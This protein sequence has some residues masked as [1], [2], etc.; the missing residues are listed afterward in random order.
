MGNRCCWLRFVAASLTLLAPVYAAA[1]PTGP[2]VV[3]FDVLFGSQ[4]Y[5]LVGSSRTD[6]PWHITGIDVV[7]SEPIASGDVNSLSGVSASGF[8]GLGTNTLTWNFSTLSNGN[9]S[10]VLAGAGPDALKD[11]M[12]NALNGGAGFTQA[13]SVLFGDFDGDGQVNSADLAGA[14]AAASQAYNIFADINGDGV[15]NSVD[16][17]LVA[18]AITRVPEPT[19]LALLGLGMVGLGVFAVRKR[20]VP[21]CSDSAYTIVARD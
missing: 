4:S 11:S 5:N 2:T 19:T 13:F 18:A 10:F 15:V 9:Y 16:A 20:R 1:V 6:L 14:I 3:S 21:D 17:S 12:G 8:S 7:F